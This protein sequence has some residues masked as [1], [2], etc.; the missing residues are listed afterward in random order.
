M[1]KQTLIDLYLKE[2]EYQEKVFG[3]YKNNPNLNISSFL[4][5]IEEYLDRSKKAY[6]A[7]WSRNLPEWLVSCSESVGGKP[8]PIETYEDLIKVFALTGAAIEAFLDVDVVKWR[9]EGIKTKWLEDK[10]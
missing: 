5:F 8:A 10:T 2:R 9:S 6:A 3:D 4:N 7:N 1:D